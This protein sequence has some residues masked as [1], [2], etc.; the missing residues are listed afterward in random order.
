[1]ILD[2]NDVDFQLTEYIDE[3]FLPEKAEI[4]HEA[5]DL[6]LLFKENNH[7]SEY[8][9]LINQSSYLDNNDIQDSIIVKLN[10]HLNE[11]I[12]AH[13]L[14]IN[15]TDDIRYKVHVLNALYLIMHLEDYSFIITTLETDLTDIEK[16]SRILAEYCL[17]SEEDIMSLFN[18]VDP[19]FMKLLNQYA[20]DK[21]SVAIIDS[22]ES[23]QTVI[24][25]LKL[26]NRMH[27]DTT[28]LGVQLLKSNIKPNLEIQTYVT[29]LDNQYDF[30]NISDIDSL[31]LNIFS[32]L[33]I[34]RSN[35]NGLLHLYRKNSHLLLNNINTVS[36]VES[37]L[38]QYLS[39]FLDRK[40]I[41]Q[42][43]AV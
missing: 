14:Y 24:N 23:D 32:L 4:I 15:D 36:A 29:L 26:L 8:I 12:E 22:D 33:L 7:E 25:N 1:M 20:L 42:E 38:I 5:F 6:L 19:V 18:Q 37:K 9:D 40:K 10:Q 13:K 2:T 3:N 16:L 39:Q 31:S 21:E 35:L 17:L 11:L 28:L 27:K 43:A 41:E 34:S 30:N